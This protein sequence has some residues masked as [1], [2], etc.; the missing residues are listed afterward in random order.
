VESFARPPPQQEVPLIVKQQ[1]MQIER[2]MD[3]IQM[4]KKKQ[5]STIKVMSSKPTGQ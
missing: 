3:K 2:L 4:R 5:P 1:S